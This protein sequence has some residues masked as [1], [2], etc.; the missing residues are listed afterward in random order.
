MKDWRWV[1][2]PGFEK[3]SLSMI[4]KVSKRR[5]VEECYK[6]QAAKAYA[7]EL[8]KSGECPPPSFK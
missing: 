6:D 8:I 5:S 3:F 4:D 2:L 7:L 1:F